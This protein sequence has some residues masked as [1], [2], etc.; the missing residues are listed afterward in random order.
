VGTDLIF[1]EAVAEPVARSLSAYLLPGM[2][3]T[4]S[5]EH[6]RS[7]GTVYL[8]ADT[9]A[10]VMRDIADSLRQSG[11]KRLVLVN[12]HGGNWI[13]KTALRQYNRDHPDFRV[14]LINPEIPAARYAEI[15]THPAGDIHAG[16]FETSLMMHLHPEWVGDVPVESPRSFPP[17]SFLDYFDSSELTAEGHWGWPE[18]ATAEK[19]RRAFEQLQIAALETVRQIT[20]FEPRPID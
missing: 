7:R 20:A 6:R 17:Q 5:I 10:L 3:I 13:L 16:E 14:I 15:F 2:A 1:A 4:S 11:F 8:R 18:A 9:L 19:G 12:F